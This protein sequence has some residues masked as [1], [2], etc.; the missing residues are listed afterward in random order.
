MRSSAQYSIQSVVLLIFMVLLVG[1]GD[2]TSTVAPAATSTP[3]VAAT[4]IPLATATPT[5]VVSPTS[6]PVPTVAPGPVFATLGTPFQVRLNNPGLI[7]EAGLEISLSSVNDTRCPESLYLACA[8]AGEITVVFALKKEGANSSSSISLTVPTS[9]SYPEKNN[10]TLE[11]YVFTLLKV[12][13]PRHTTEPQPGKTVDVIP[14]N[15]ADYV[16][17]LQVKKAA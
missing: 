16:A 6:T 15:L 5:R 9:V 7:K 4:N 3:P 13:P 10:K 14:I 11:G 1:C 8:Q 17:T 2:V 12:E